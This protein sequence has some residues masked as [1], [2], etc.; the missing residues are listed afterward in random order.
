MKVTLKVLALPSQ[1]TLL[2]MVIIGVVLAAVAASSLPGSPMGAAPPLAVILGVLTLRDF[3]MQ[4]GRE[5]ET[6]RLVPLPADK[7]PRL[8]STLREQAALISHDLPPRA[9]LTCKTPGALFAFGSFRR[10][11]IGIGEKI[12][13]QIERDRASP[14][15]QYRAQAEAA[16][17]HELQHLSQR[18]VIIVGLARSLL[19]TS[20][21]FMLWSGA[22]FLGLIT[23]AFA[24]PAAELFQPEFVSRMAAAS[25]PLASIIGS[26]MTPELMEKARQAPR[27]DLAGLYVLNAHLPILITT[28][29]L[30]LS[31][32]RQLLKARELYADAATAALQNNSAGIDSALIRYGALAALSAGPAQTGLRRFRAIRQLMGTLSGWN[33]RVT[34]FTG[35]HPTIAARRKGLENPVSVLTDPVWIGWTTDGLVLLLDLLLIGPFTLGYVTEAPGALGQ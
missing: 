22:F 20:A 34:N 18:D 15:S 31:V 2:F 32:W 10:S 12:A 11:Y 35:F 26:L 7:Y 1:T 33:V 6:H 27:W 3:L 17:T 9:L 13:G 23:V 8:A 16:L 24:F 14:L 21:L 19:K 28:F 5:I 25:P 29:V 30:F 4:P